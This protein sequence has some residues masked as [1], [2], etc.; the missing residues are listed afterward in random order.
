[1]QLALVNAVSPSNAGVGHF[2]ISISGSPS[3][4]T[5]FYFDEMAFY[6][7]A[8]TSAGKFLRSDGINTFLSTITPGDLP[9]SGFM[10]PIGLPQ[11]YTG[12]TSETDVLPG[13]TLPANSVYPGMLWEY[14]CWGWVTTTASTQTVKFRS[15]YGTNIPSDTGPVAP[16][17]SGTVTNAVWRWSGKLQFTSASQVTAQGQLDTNYYPSVVASNAFG[18]STTSAQQLYVSYVPSDTAVSLTVTGGY[19]KQ[20][21]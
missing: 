13:P 8:S 15:H 4:S 21:N 7:G 2:N 16:Y 9:A 5:L 11:T 10:T 17:A 19:W 1:M 3:V 18:V 12:F 14:C 20:C 6:V